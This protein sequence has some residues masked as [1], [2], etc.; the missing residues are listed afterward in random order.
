[1]TATPTRRVVAALTAKGAEVRFVGGCV[2]D[3]LAGRPVKDIDIATH[4]P[5]A[6]VIAL[7]EAAGLRAI[8]T[9]LAHGTVTAIADHKPFE[10]T[11]LREDV[12]TFGRHA[13]VTFTDDWTADAARRDFTFNALSCAPDGTLY[14]PFGGIAD[15][16]AGRVRFVGDPEAR[17]REDYLRL[18]RFFRFQAHYG[19]TPPEPA[20]L[21]IAEALAPALQ[22]LSGERIRNELFKTLLAP[23]PLPVVELMLARGILRPVL[24]VTGDVHV[25]AA[26]L[27][28][29]RAAAPG[30]TPEPPDPVLRLA[31]LIK[32][33]RAAA[34]AA[35]ERLRL[36]NR[37]RFALLHLAEPLFD[38]LDDLSPRDRHRLVRKLSTPLSRAL[39]RLS[40]ARRH[41]GEPA[42]RPGPGL[43][44]ALA[45]VPRLAAI[46][47]PLSGRDALAAGVPEGPAIGRLLDAVEDWWAAQD[48]RPGRKACLGRLRALAR[49]AV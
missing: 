16:Q 43:A 13:R 24:P 9:G 23:D 38:P 42:P 5:P 40:W 49:D 3:A 29:E 2:R 32:P 30:E 33:Q 12:E 11:T 48:F 27:A 15:L 17:I 31:A 14:D 45:E 35:A 10:I 22:R 34:E 26:L 4:L 20:V 8:P 7:L 37:Q 46:A 19:R 21:D 6:E 41:A 25:L 28:A 36:S 1:M 18:L 44:E 39:L 47:F